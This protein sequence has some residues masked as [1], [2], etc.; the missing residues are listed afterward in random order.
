MSEM[1]SIEAMQVDRELIC[2]IQDLKID[3]IAGR[4]SLA[5]KDCIPPALQE[6]A[7]IAGVEGDLQFDLKMQNRI[8]E[9][10]KRLETEFPDGIPLSDEAIGEVAATTLSSV[11]GERASDSD[12]VMR[13]IDAAILKS[14]VVQLTRRLN[15]NT[16]RAVQPKAA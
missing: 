11:L 3:L 8:V 10:M 4:D 9:H 7:G 16:L 15:K 13:V 2:D 1:R 12:E 14:L 5:L 6:F